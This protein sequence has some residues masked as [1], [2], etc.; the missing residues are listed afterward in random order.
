M[1]RLRRQVTGLLLVGYQYPAVLIPWFF[2]AVAEGIAVTA[3]Y[4]ILVRRAPA[5]PARACLPADRS[6]R[7]LLL[8]RGTPTEERLAAVLVYVADLVEQN[9]PCWP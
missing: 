6:S 2:L 4:G 3:T 9:R 5:L 1:K 8:E 7:I